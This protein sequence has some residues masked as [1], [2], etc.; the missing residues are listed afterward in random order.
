[1]EVGTYSVDLSFSKQRKSVSVHSSV[2]HS[3]INHVFLTKLQDLENIKV[4]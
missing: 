3:T 2:T 4:G 1:M